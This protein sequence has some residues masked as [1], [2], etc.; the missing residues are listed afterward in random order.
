MILAAGVAALIILS[1]IAWLVLVELHALADGD[2]GFV[3]ASVAGV[4]LLCALYAG[5]GF[6]LRRIGWI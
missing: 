2:M 4:L 1:A 3:A 6:W 5:T